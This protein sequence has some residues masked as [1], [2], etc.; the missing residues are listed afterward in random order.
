ML[1]NAAIQRGSQLILV[2]NDG[3]IDDLPA[4]LPQNARIWYG[5]SAPALHGPLVSIH[6]IERLHHRLAVLIYC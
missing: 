4:C 5:I 2:F 1:Q 3:A 6:I